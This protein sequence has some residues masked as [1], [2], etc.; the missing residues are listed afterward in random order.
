MSVTR[1]GVNTQTALRLKSGPVYSEDDRGRAQ[2]VYEYYCLASSVIALLPAY[3]A[4]APD[5][6][7]ASLLRREVQAAPHE[8]GGVILTV[9]YREP[10]GSTPPAV[11]D[12]TIETNSTLNEVPIEQIVGIT[13][14]ELNAARAKNVKT[15]LRFPV[16]VTRR[17]V[18]SSVTLSEANLIADV[19]TRQAPTGV[20]SPTANAWVK[21]G[22]AYSIGDV[23]TLTETW[24]YDVDLWQNIEGS[25]AFA[26]TTTTT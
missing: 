19:G 22:K 5:S 9:I 20:T 24:A 3:N 26:T 14:A 25:S 6:Q 16:V 13:E 10:G 8:P 15:V 23:I 7:Y 1:Y 17:E 2:V 12:I 21:T 4:A 18:V 11:G